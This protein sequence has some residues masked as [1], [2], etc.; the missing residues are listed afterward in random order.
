MKLLEILKDP[1]SPS[2]APC[3]PGSGSRR[4]GPHPV[5]APGRAGRCGGEAA[6]QAGAASP[7]LR[8]TS[9]LAA[10]LRALGR[11]GP[12]PPSMRDFF[13]KGVDFWGTTLYNNHCSFEEDA[14]DNDGEVA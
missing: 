8:P 9:A 3:R 12:G 10:A 2:G 6:L 14:F 1:A 4:P 13:E 11:D 5:W 7:P